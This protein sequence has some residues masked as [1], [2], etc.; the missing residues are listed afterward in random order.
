[1]IVRLF[2]HAVV[3]INGEYWGILNIREKINSNFLAENHFVNPDN[4]NLL[5]FNGNVIEGQTV[6]IMILLITLNT[7]TLET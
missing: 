3:Y 1:M 6:P 2:S 5:E 4:V 7:N